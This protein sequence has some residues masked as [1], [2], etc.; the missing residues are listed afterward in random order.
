MA[1][2]PREMALNL[3]FTPYGYSQGAWRHNASRSN[4]TSLSLYRDLARLAERAKL[5]AIFVADVLGWSVR[6]SPRELEP[7]TVLSALAGVTEKIGLIG[8]IST[9]FTEPFNTAR[10]LTSLDHLSSGRA[11]WNIVT[12]VGG[13]S[14]FS[15]KLAPHDER[16]EIADEY[17]KVVTALWDSWDDDAVV[18]DRKGGIWFKPE[19]VRRI[20]HHGK[21]FS[22]EGP[23]LMPR[24]PQG[25]PVLAQAGSS[26]RGTDLAARWADVVYTAQ[27]DLQQARAFYQMVK[28]KVAAAGRAPEHV[29]ILPGFQPI[30]GDSEQAA[31]KLADEI[32]ELIPLEYAMKSLSLQFGGIETA[33]LNLDEPVPLDRIPSREK[34]AS[35][36]F[37]IFHEFA[38]DKRCRLRDL[39]RLAGTAGGHS[40]HVGTAEQVADEMER[41]FLTGA[42]DGF[43]LQMATSS[44]SLH[45]IC[46]QLIPELRRRGLFRSEYEGETLRDHLRVPRPAVKRG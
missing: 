19:R 15:A 27:P 22:V 32:A 25:W 45:A 37:D 1:R 39:L 24:S 28:G 11:G 43:A 14:N 31:R 33:G 7:I 9:T 42:C 30:I 12:S 4:E 20:D 6:Q 23:A 36:R 26:P 40:M 29:K 38:V 35:S 16:Y 13:D 17:L 44:G 10:Y 5:D 2:S 34:A 41:W 46:E 21:F 3:V 18:N 8:T